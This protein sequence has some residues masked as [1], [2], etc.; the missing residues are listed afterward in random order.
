MN[1]ILDSGIILIVFFGAVLAGFVLLGW[2]VVG[3][4]KK[5]ARLLGGSA[6]SGDAGQDILRRLAHSEA[7]L[8]VME[9]R[10]AA[11]EEALRSGIRKVGFL[12][13]NPFP[14]TGGDQSFI[15][16]LLD[17]ENTGI[18]LSSL[19]RREGMRLY[20]KAVDR[21]AARQ[22]LSEEEERVLEET[23]NKN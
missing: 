17:A 16:A 11:A 18:V 7:H 13:F 20:G 21:G 22:T 3:I 23:I 4:R 19:Y 8:E 14:D 15:I 2:T 9:P 6:P 5:M 10:L 12:R 1:E